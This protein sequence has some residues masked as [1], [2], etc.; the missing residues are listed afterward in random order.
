VLKSQ[1][2]QMIEWKIKIKNLEI[3]KH[4][5]FKKSELLKGENV[6]NEFLIIQL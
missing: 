4:K 5:S 6:N 1:K 3:A 2:F